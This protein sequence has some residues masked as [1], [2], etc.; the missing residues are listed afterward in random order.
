MTTVFNSVDMVIDA[1]E[2]KLFD[3][4]PV[5]NSLGDAMSLYAADVKDT[6]KQFETT[7]T[8]HTKTSITLTCNMFGSSVP[9][10]FNTCDLV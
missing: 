10:T 3:T 6:F 1:L 9:F 8:N 2:N 7:C 5:Y 4:V